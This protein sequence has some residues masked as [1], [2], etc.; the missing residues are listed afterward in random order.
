MSGI[1][2][3]SSWPLQKN[4]QYF[5]LAENGTNKTMFFNLGTFF[6]KRINSCGFCQT[7]NALSANEA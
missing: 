4:P 7:E 6:L 5:L 2:S 3:P 1:Q